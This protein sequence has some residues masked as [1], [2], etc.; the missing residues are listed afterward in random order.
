MK[1][2]ISLSLTLALLLQILAVLGGFSFTT[3]AAAGAV[4]IDSFDDY[5]RLETAD[6]KEGAG[7]AVELISGGSGTAGVFCGVSR[8]Y[9]PA[10]DLSASA[11]PDAYVH[12][13]FYIRNA[14]YFM[15][16]PKDSYLELSSSG[17]GW[18]SGAVRYDLSGLNVVDGWNELFLPLSGFQSVDGSTPCDWSS[19]NFFRLYTHNCKSDGGVF[20]QVIMVDELSIGKASDFSTFPRNAVTKIENFDFT[21][22]YYSVSTEG[23]KEGIAAAGVTG[24]GLTL[25]ERVYSRAKDLSAYVGKENAYIHF[26]LYVE[27]VEYINNA[28][29]RLEIS[30]GGF[31]GSQV[32]KYDVKKM[33]LK[34]GWN[35]LYLPVSGFET[36]DPN[37]GTCNWGRVNYIRLYLQNG[38]HTGAA[39]TQTM[40]MDGMEI[41]IYDVPAGSTLKQI[42]SYDS[43]LNFLG[44]VAADTTQKVEGAASAMVTTTATGGGILSAIETRYTYARNL[45]YY[46]GRTDAYVHI[47]LYLENAD[48]FDNRTF[49]RLELSSGTGWGANVDRYDLSTVK[50]NDGW[51]DLYL[52][53]S[54]FTPEGNGDC[55]WSS[56]NYTRV[57]LFNNIAVSGQTMRVDDLSIGLASD[58]D[59]PAASTKQ[60]LES[61]DNATKFNVD[62]AEKQEGDGAAKAEVTIDGNANY[63]TIFEAYYSQTKDLSAYID[64]PDAYVHL[65]LYLENAAWFRNDVDARLELSS[66]GN[67][68]ANAVSYD[69]TRQT[70][71]DG[72]NEVLIPVSQL[73]SM[74]NGDCDFAHI[75][76]I[77]VFMHHIRFG[78]ATGT[79]VMRLDALEIGKQA[80]FEQPEQPGT[81]LKLE[82][83][84]NPNQFTLDTQEKKEGSASAVSTATGINPL[85]QVENIYSQRKD[86]SF[87]QQTADTYIQLQLYVEDAGLL[88]QNQDMFLEIGS[89]GWYGAEIA[90]YDLAGLE[91]VNGWNELLVPVS[92][93]QDHTDPSVTACDWSKI[94]Y[95]RLY[96]FSVAASG[97]SVSQ[98]IRLDGMYIGV[99]EDF[100]FTEP[101]ETTRRMIES[102]DSA[103]KF[104]LDTQD[105]KQGSA[106]A[107][108]D[109]TD[110]GEVLSMLESGYR[111]PMDL[112][113]FA[114]N[115]EAYLHLWVYVDDA[116][117]LDD[118][119]DGF[120]EI[121]SGGAWDKNISRYDIVGLAFEDG[122]N[123]LLIPVS[124]VKAHTDPAVGGCDWS[125]VNYIR[126][127]M[128]SASMSGGTLRQIMK[129]DGLEIGLKSDFAD[130]KP[131]GS[132]YVGTQLR[133]IEPFD[134]SRYFSVDTASKKEGYGSA[135]IQDSAKNELATVI[136]RGYTKSMDL[137]AFRNTSKAYI[138]LWVYV[139]DASAVDPMKDGYVEIGSAGTWNKHISRYD[140]SALA[141]RDGWNEL[142]IPVKAFIDHT[143]PAVG[144]CDWSA[145]NYIRIYLHS[146]AMG[147]GTIRQTMRTDG[148]QIGLIEE[149]ANADPIGPRY[150][151]TQ[152]RILEPFE[153]AKY[154]RVDTSN[155][156]EGAASAKVTVSGEGKLL[157]AVDRV[158]T[159]TTDLSAF[160]RED[161]YFRFWLYVEDA[162]LVD[163][164]VDTYF[165]IGSGGGWDK[166][167]SRY[168]LSGLQLQDGWNEVYVPLSKMQAH[169]DPAVGS[170]DWSR[171]N[172]VRIYLHHS[173]PY[174]VSC[175]QTVAVDGLTIGLASDMDV[176]ESKQI[177][178]VE[179]YDDAHRFTVN[180][181]NFKEGSGAAVVTTEAAGNALTAFESFYAHTLDLSYYAQLEDGCV[182]FWLYIDNTDYLSQEQD[183]YVEFSSGGFWG[184]EVARHDLIG[185]DLQQGWNR[186]VL[187]I[188]SFQSLPGADA[189]PCDWSRI[190]YIR[191]YLHHNIPG[192]SAPQTVMVDEMRVGQLAEFATDDAAAEGEVSGLFGSSPHRQEEESVP[193]RGKLGSI[194]LW[195]AV[196]IVLA[197]ILTVAL[198]L[199]RRKKK[200]A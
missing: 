78:G 129:A 104:I 2:L 48:F 162:S 144:G 75:N 110:A 130:A 18:T 76:Y 84:D 99:K 122:W 168:P 152:L 95:I 166:H 34:S 23:A 20:D 77:R 179:P 182:A 55:D 133:M 32:A 175:K 64:D 8:A 120:L 197:A 68:A 92:E 160:V 33:D 149:F 156:K 184:S 47:S 86:L 61:Y 26:W 127:Y 71:V 16:A 3:E 94:N 161:A 44:S 150:S 37:I 176:P 10:I 146:T 67:Y 147:G 154:F 81:L 98:T 169:P 50:L 6:Q 167:V 183:G 30:S 163:T 105:K 25:I 41:G 115:E 141:F 9:S 19:I 139:K 31:W 101:D 38:H 35:E 65:W 73:Q 116:S 170:C 188:R 128:F 178:L 82:G 200:A 97:E 132:R 194:A 186:I 57:Y 131:I 69:L 171:M 88:N 45:S 196:P 126:L 58:F 102:F 165:E 117:V 193:Q 96:A 125:A 113:A 62:S 137:S 145:V 36:L 12:I 89:G 143:D 51:N 138:H 192:A 134:D 123:E 91:L 63:P 195:C 118:Q 153:D 87:Y 40:R 119:R 46:K 114:E 172:Y 4:L 43:T 108:S 79:Q 53:V 191:V 121:G 15:A 56:I 90:R 28:D 158:Y 59:I 106:S 21:T 185:R 151:G 140:I 142:L 27:N 29:G 13:W 112:S 148:M 24:N 159:K 100:E 83:F 135:V 74:G 190:N 174:A 164:S 22:P 70:F 111:K 103:S 180:T 136:D 107:V 60:M 1:R 93:F 181:E 198:V 7:A 39:V 5:G 66:G 80:D 155:K 11:T 49:A 52:P 199:Y 54:G 173:D 14:D 157:T 124:E 72:W 187:P 17:A 177:T 109:V 85:T 189:V 42:E